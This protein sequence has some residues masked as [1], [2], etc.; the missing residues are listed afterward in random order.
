[1][2]HCV[3][4]TGGSSD[5]LE[6]PPSAANLYG[7][8][9]PNQA[10]QGH[11]TYRMW[12]WGR[13]N[14]RRIER[15]QPTMTK[16]GP[17]YLHAGA[18]SSSGITPYDTPSTSDSARLSLESGITASPLNDSTQSHEYGCL[19]SVQRVGHWLSNLPLEPARWQ[20][21]RGCWVQPERKVSRP[22]V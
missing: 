20:D 18:N 13:R 2:A 16:P 7:D 4:Q 19:P 10:S 21:G 11:G 22:F 5:G 12:H 6:A 14:T 1:M 17:R 8:A 9:T 3:V 15:D